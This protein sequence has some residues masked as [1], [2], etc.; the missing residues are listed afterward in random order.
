VHEDMHQELL[1]WLLL[2]SNSRQVVEHNTGRV[3]WALMYW[4]PTWG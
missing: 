1:N 3:Y 2:S 4:F